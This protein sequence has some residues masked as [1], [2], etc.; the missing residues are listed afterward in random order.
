MAFTDAQIRAA[1][2]NRLNALLN[3]YNDM[4][5][6]SL[7]LG[8]RFMRRGRFLVVTTSGTQIIF[9]KVGRALEGQCGAIGA[10]GKVV[11]SVPPSMVTAWQANDNTETA[12]DPNDAVEL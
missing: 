2:V 1:L 6:L 10:P 9:I 7:T 5:G 4:T 3:S 11:G 12:L 8:A